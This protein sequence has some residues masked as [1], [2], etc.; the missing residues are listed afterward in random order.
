MQVNI[1][2]SFFCVMPCCLGVFEYDFR[3]VAVPGINSYTHIEVQ[4]YFLGIDDKTL[5]EGIEYLF[6]DLVGDCSFRNP[7]H[8]EVKLVTTHPGDGIV[9]SQGLIESFGEVLD[10][11]VTY[12]MSERFIN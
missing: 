3:S 4:K 8:Q 12:F 5:P 10:E 11:Q 2:S 7:R 1:P 6:C 9:L